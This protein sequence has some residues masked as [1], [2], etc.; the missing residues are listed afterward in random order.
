MTRYCGVEQVKRFT[1]MISY[2]DLGFADE[3]SYEDHI[4]ECVE[5]ASRSIDRY[6][7]RPNDFF[8]GGVMIPELQDGKPYESGDFYGLSWRASRT[9]KK[10]RTFWLGQHPV[11]SPVTIAGEAVGTATGIG[12]TMDLDYNPLVALSETIYADGAE[13]TR[14]TDYTI[15]NSLGQIT[16]VTDQSGKA[17][18][19]DYQYTMKIEVNKASIGSADDWQQIA[20]TN[21]RV[22]LSTGKII[23]ATGAIPAEGYENVRFT[24]KAGYSAVPSD[25]KQVCAQL[26]SNELHAEA[27]RYTEQLTKWK[28]PEPLDFLVPEVFTKEMKRKLAPYMKRRI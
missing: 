17:I 8:N 20:S 28:K 11:I 15:D 1:R 7:K 25:M 23:F 13:L 4:E 10:R 2:K 27:Q 19:A 9:I 16:W 3:D 26:V 5:A 21:Y 22:N 14:T 6:C 12:T 18:T 24:Y